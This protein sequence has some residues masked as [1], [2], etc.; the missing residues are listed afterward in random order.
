[1]LLF[2]RSSPSSIHIPQA[3]SQ[4]GTPIHRCI[5]TSTPST[6]FRCRLS[7]R[8]ATSTSAAIKT[9]GVF[10]HIDSTS[11]SRLKYGTKSLVTRP[12]AY[13]LIKETRTGSQSRWEGPVALSSPSAGAEYWRGR[14]K[15]MKTLSGGLRTRRSLMRKVG[16]LWN[17]YGI[18][19]LVWML[20]SESSCQSLT[21][22]QS[23]SLMR[24]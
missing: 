19:S 23:Q 12:K 7:S 18:L 15:I 21:T 14:G 22:N 2:P 20:S 24:A 4:P 17:F 5:L 8:T 3:F 16:G 6:P 9:Q 11:T 13:S 10:L 1:M